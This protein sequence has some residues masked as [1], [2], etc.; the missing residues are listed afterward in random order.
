MV[1]WGSNNAARN[2]ARIENSTI[3]VNIGK[4]VKNPKQNLKVLLN[5]KITQRTA[6]DFG[7]ISEG[8]TFTLTSFL[9]QSS[10][11]NPFSTL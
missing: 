7:S 8:G 4:D 2:L 6:V 3:N 10:P 1:F 11:Y 5:N 9:F